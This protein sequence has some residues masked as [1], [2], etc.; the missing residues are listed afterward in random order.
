MCG[1]GATLCVFGAPEAQPLCEV[2]HVYVHVA[3]GGAPAVGKTTCFNNAAVGYD[4]YRGVAVHV[5]LDLGQEPQDELDIAFATCSIQWVTQVFVFNESL[6]RVRGCGRESADLRQQC[7]CRS[8]PCVLTQI[9]H[10]LGSAALN[11]AP[12]SHLFLSFSLSL[13]LSCS[14]SLACCAAYWGS[15]N[16][17]AYICGVA[18]V[19]EIV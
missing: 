6:P 18:N 13:F 1:K 11:S 4:V 8:A 5:R 9:L 15:N 17:A 7:M 3:K 16:Q 19:F 12:A 10:V 14:F 2:V